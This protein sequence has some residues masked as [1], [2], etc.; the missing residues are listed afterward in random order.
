MKVIFIAG[1]WGSGTTMVI[2]AL[3]RL[4]VP[5]F[6]PHFESDDPRT[7]NTYELMPFR[8]LILDHVDE[9]SMMP[10]NQFSSDADFSRQLTAALS[11]FGRQLERG[12]FGPWPDGNPKVVALKTPLASVCLPEITQVFDT[13]II[14]VH[15]PLNE[16]EASRLRREWAEY[17]G[18]AGATKVYT[19]M[20]SDLFERKLS[21]LMI[22]HGDFVK[23]TRDALKKIINYCDLHFL[24]HNI[25]K[26]MNF[27]KKPTA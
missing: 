12:D 22:S 13:D 5:T 25:E 21:A 4:G 17:F 24:E 19:K 27:V 2:G 8:E 6:G 1:S 10:K 23:D 9:S 26:A 20:F 16:I 11:L 15:R 3:D 7:P 18:A 14:L